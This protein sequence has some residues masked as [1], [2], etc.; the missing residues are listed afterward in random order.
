MTTLNVELANAI[1]RDH[2]R[3]FPNHTRLS[4]TRQTKPQRR[5]L[6][7]LRWFPSHRV[8]PAV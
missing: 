2:E 6:P 5:V 7:R 4:N 3:E 8:R 1:T